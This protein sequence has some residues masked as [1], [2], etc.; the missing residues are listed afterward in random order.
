MSFIFSTLPCLIPLF[1]FYPCASS[2]DPSPL[3]YFW[4]RGVV[5][6]E[7]R[8][9]ASAQFFVGNDP[10]CTLYVRLWSCKSLA[11]TH[12]LWRPHDSFFRTTPLFWSNSH[13]PSS[14][15]ASG[16][17]IHLP[18]P[19][20][21]PFHLFQILSTQHVGAKAIQADRSGC[22]GAFSDFLNVWP[23][24]NEA[25]PPILEFF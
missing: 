2:L 12:F 17:S 23:W 19:A 8:W 10:L 21:T 25:F 3:T 5:G 15:T 18:N 6:C 24:D 9:M 11:S 7:W 16:L 22:V 1:F 13:L 20:Q 4:S 14:V